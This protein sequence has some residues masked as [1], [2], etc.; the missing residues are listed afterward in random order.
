MYGVG[1]G[2]S[3]FPVYGHTDPA[4]YHPAPNTV[5]NTTQSLLDKVTITFTDRNELM[6]SS[7]KVLN[8][9]NPIIDSMV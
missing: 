1:T 6:A 9:N 4:T 8:S 3:F 2:L 7:T 5:S